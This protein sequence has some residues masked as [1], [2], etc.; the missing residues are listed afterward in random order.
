LVQEKKR[1]VLPKLELV[2]QLAVPE[3]QVLHQVCEQLVVIEQGQQLVLALQNLLAQP[4]VALE[5]LPPEYCFQFGQVSLV[6]EQLVHPAQ[7]YLE[8]LQ[9]LESVV[10]HPWVN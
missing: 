2:L 6:L 9:A 3:L 8:E 10:F 4:L 5:P 1:Q 7:K